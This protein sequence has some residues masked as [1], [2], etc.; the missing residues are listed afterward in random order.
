MSPNRLFN[1]MQPKM[2][3][4]LETEIQLNLLERAINASTNGIIITDAQQDDH[5]I[6][7]VNEAF[8]QMTGYT[9]N[10]VVGCNCRFLH[11]DN[12]QQQ[13]LIKIRSALREGKECYAVLKNYRKDGTEFW[14]ELYIA[15]IRNV[16]NQITHHIGVQTDVTERKQAEDI[17]KQSEAQFRQTFECAPIGMALVGVDGQFLEVNPALCKMLG[18]SQSELMTRSLF[19]ISHPDDLA[20]GKLLYR[21]CLQGEIQTFQLEKRYLDRNENS[22]Y[23]LVRA[24]LVRNENQVPSHYVV[25]ILDLS[26][27]LTQP[28]VPD[29]PP[30]MRQAI[31]TPRPTLPNYFHYDSL[32]GLPT[33]ILFEEYLQEALRQQQ[34]AVFFLDLDRFQIVNKSLGHGA[35]DQLLTAIS[36]RLED[37]LQRHDLIARSGGDEFAIF[38]EGVD[39]ASQAVQIAKL[40]Q[41]K[42][43]A[44][45]TLN[46]SEGK[47]T[48]SENFITTTVGLTLANGDTSQGKGQQLLQN[49]EIA[50]GRA[51]K[52]GKAG[53]AVFD[54]TLGET[55]WRQ[56]RLETDLKTA[57]AQED[58]YV[59][60]QPIMNLVTGKVSGFEALVRWQHPKLGLVSPGEFIPL[61]E[62]TGL[63]IPIGYW[64]LEQACQQLQRWQQRFPS[65]QNLTMSV[66]LSGL[67]IKDPALVKKVEAI[68]SKTGLAG[69]QL[70]LELTETALIENFDL[71]T[72]QLQQLKTHHIQLSIDDFGTGYSSLSYLQQFPVDVLKIDRSFVSAMTPDNQNLKIVQA[73]ISLAHALELVVIG[74]GIETAYQQE[75]LRALGC[76]Q[77]QGYYYAKPLGA[78]QATEFLQGKLND[79]ATDPNFT[80]PD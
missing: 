65:D 4:M 54:E 24:T 26:C 76:G 10:E 1:I 34:G 62:E 39:T 33:R 21:R 48:T 75:Q 79:G 80:A 70:K 16:Q 69:N 42:L 29:N 64:V 31:P 74:E 61:A 49:A 60:Y 45:F 22:I 41:Q 51:K 72:E 66:N 59:Q 35:G 5:P 23:A 13:N 25:Q 18:Y 7:Y 15:P 12:C 28:S 27:P 3:E 2:L 57:L 40:F 43:T 58:L 68:L 38:V 32:T 11:G 67:Q 6:I 36:A 19:E 20:E 30:A 53:V 37:S 50:L 56:S 71:A 44:P 46:T 14:N 55:V 47:I 8:E 63:V 9:F 78:V 52:K 77:G 73:V 17:L